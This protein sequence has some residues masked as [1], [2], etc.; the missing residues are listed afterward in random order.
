MPGRDLKASMLALSREY[1]V[2]LE[3][4]PFAI[5]PPV[6]LERAV[7]RVRKRH[8]DGYSSLA[9]VDRLHR[10]LVKLR[11]RGVDGLKRGDRF[12]LAHLLN[13]QSDLLAGKSVLETASVANPVLLAWEQEARHG[14]I[15]PSHWRGLFHSYLQAPEGEGTDRMRTL[16]R[17]GLSSLRGSARPP[18]WLDGFLKHEDLLGPRPC[19][20]YV[21]EIVAGRSA[22]REDLLGIVTVPAASWYWATLSRELVEKLDDLS[23]EAFKKII[24]AVLALA[25]HIPL[26][27]DLILAGVLNRYEETTDRDRHLLLLQHSLEKWGSPQLTRSA[28]WAQVRPRTKSMVMGWLAQEDLEDFYRLCRDAGEVDDRRL[29]Y[30]IGFKDQITYSQIVLGSRLALSR[31]KDIRDFMQRK[32]GRLGRLTSGTADN[33]AIIMRIGKL[34]FV[35]FSQMGNA[36][37]PYLEEHLPFT[38]GTEA[39]SLDD[40]KNVARVTRSKTRRLLH[41][42]DWETDVFDPALS[43]WGIGIAARSRSPS[44][45]TPHRTPDKTNGLSAALLDVIKAE[46]GKV[47][48]N[49]DKGGALWILNPKGSKRL[50]DRLQALGYRA[51]VGKGFYLP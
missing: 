16:L 2:R 51:K 31:N 50:A 37:Y 10:V 17:A 21:A 28:Q 34:L 24:T 9:T 7:R 15:R 45:S 4:G 32:Q 25:D 33:N 49:R 1:L 12:V 20:Q 48:D 13:E 39:Y 35:E 22:L 30:W 46:G 47:L 41:I 8:G 43:S 5:R 27:S 11:A 40:L 36:C 42:G 3:S 44:K 23:D 29:K 18:A 6:E 14:V 38:L 19:A 26:R